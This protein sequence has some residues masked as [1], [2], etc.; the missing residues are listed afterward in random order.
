MRI[1]SLGRG[2]VLLFPLI[3]FCLVLPRRAAAQECEH[4]ALRSGTLSMDGIQR[5]RVVAGAGSLELTG[6]AGAGEVRASGRACASGADDLAEVVIRLRRSGSTAEIEVLYPEDHIQFG[7]H[8]AYLNLEVVVP[9]GVSVRIEDGSGNLTVSGTGRTEVS[10]GSGNIT[11]RDIRGD[12][13]IEDGSGNIDVEGVAGSVG[14]DD[15]SGEVEIAD[16]RGSV[17]VEDG[18]GDVRVRGVGGSVEVED[19]SGD[20]RITQV[21][22]DVRIEED[23]SGSIRVEEVGGDFTVDDDGSGSVIHAGITGRVSLPDDD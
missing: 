10:D 8:Y 17:A 12:L 1:P 19:G 20:I 7:N 13:R 11:A 4:A 5:V 14:I 2:A 22:R 18:S 21:I 9:Q 16:A 23:G 15:G 3:L 6:V